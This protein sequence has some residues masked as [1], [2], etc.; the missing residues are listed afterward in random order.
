VLYSEWETPIITAL[1][2]LARFVTTFD[3]LNRLHSAMI[4]M[5]LVAIAARELA[6]ARERK[7]TPNPPELAISA[8]LEVG[9]FAMYARSFLVAPQSVTAGA[10]LTLMIAD[11]TRR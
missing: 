6:G 10:P 3:L 9:V 7:E 2:E 11:C 4:D 5:Q 1:E 8:V